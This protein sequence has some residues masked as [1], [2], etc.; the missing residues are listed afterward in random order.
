M[1]VFIQPTKRRLYHGGFAGLAN[2][3]QAW[4]ALVHIKYPRIAAHFAALDLTAI[5][6]TTVWWL[7][8]FS[9]VL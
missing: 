1:S 8:G 9:I 4:D 6:Y 2:S 5:Q 3:N 7:I